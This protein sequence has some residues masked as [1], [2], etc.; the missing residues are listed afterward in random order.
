ML[1]LGSERLQKRCISCG[2]IKD[3]AF[4]P[5]HFMVDFKAFSKS[6]IE[7]R[8]IEFFGSV[9]VSPGKWRK[10]KSDIDIFLFGDNISAKTKRRYYKLFWELNEKYKLELENVPAIHP[11]IF[12]IDS[13]I[14]RIFY[15]LF[16]HSP[17]NPP[18][19]RKLLKRL[20]PPARVFRSLLSLS[21]FK[22]LWK[23]S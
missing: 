23:L 6:N 11:L 10:G 3:M 7:T 14:R 2:E 20:A 8:E 19:F 17:Y 5:K 4:G 21:R 18:K 16:K 1:R 13:P 9:V 22:V 15:F 12:F